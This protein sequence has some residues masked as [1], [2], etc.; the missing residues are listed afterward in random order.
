MEECARYKG[1]KWWR[2]GRMDM[3]KGRSGGVGWLG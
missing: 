1:G 3:R 2:D